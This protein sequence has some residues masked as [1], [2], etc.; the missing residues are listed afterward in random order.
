MTLTIPGL[1]PS[2][3][4]NWDGTRLGIRLE[5]EP[6]FTYADLIGLTGPQGPQG[7]PGATGATGA[8]GPAGPKG[9]TGATGLQGPRGLTGATGPV[10]PKGDTGATGAAGPQGPQG[11]TGPAG[12]QG[13]PGPTGPK[14]DTG[15]TGP[16]GTTTWAGITNKPSTFPPSGHQHTSFAG[17]L[18][19][20]A[21]QLDLGG[22]NSF[23][24]GNLFLRS[25]NPTIFLRDTDHPGAAIHVNGGLFYVLPMP[26]D[27]NTW[28]AING[29]WPFVVNLAT[30]EVTVGG[31]LRVGSQFPR[32]YFDDSTPGSCNYFIWCDGGIFHIFA[33]RNRDGSFEAPHPLVL[34][35]NQN[36]AWVFGR[37]I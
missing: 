15:A 8:T 26:T 37:E 13:V 34:D 33:D 35:A 24:P 1:P 19:A 7:E 12:P 36:R 18:T 6:S 21:F 28:Q 4:F 25:S 31:V 16:A 3:E 9:D 23:Q 17:T 14:G 11:L 30:N 2:L 22:T 27:Q 10:G 32:I 29:I 20:P 5:G